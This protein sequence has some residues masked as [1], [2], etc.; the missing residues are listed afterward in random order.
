[1]YQDDYN[2]ILEQSATIGKFLGVI[3]SLVKYDMPSLPNF[4][5]KILAQT[6]IECSTNIDDIIM[7]RAQAKQRGVNV[8]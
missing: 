3:G 1:M 8:G 2:T 4:E 6:Y 5:F 7:V